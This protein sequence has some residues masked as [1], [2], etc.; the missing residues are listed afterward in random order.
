MRRSVL[1]KR[2]HKDEKVALKN[3]I[4]GSD[5]SDVILVSDDALAMSIQAV[6]VIMT[7]PMLYT[8]HTQ[9]LVI[10]APIVPVPFKYF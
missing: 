8:V 1:L 2:C 3:G 6:Y 5:Q 7:A 4:H 9:R 10:Q